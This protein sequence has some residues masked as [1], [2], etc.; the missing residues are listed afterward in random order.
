MSKTLEI[1]LI[2]FLALLGVGLVLYAGHREKISS[3][4]LPYDFSIRFGMFEGQ[5]RALNYFLL[6]Y[7]FQKQHGSLQ[8]KVNNNQNIEVIYIDLFSFLDNKSTKVKVFSGGNKPEKELGEIILEKIHQNN[9][10]NEPKYTTL[11]IQNEKKHNLSDKF[12]VIEFSSEIQPNGVFTIFHQYFPVYSDQYSFNFILGNNQCPTSCFNK[13]FN[14][15]VNEHRL[16]SKKSVKLSLVE[17]DKNNQHRFKLE[18]EN[19]SWINFL[20]GLGISLIAASIVWLMQF[21]KDIV[22]YH[23]KN[24]VCP[25]CLKKFKNAHGLGVH[26]GRIHKPKN[27]LKEKDKK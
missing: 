22:R 8:F 27:W 21:T 7:D 6:T 26:K 14:L 10:V 2:T 12:I 25:L 20:N 11:V 24:N 3:D 13:D 1:M 23:Q 9:P 18:T 4:S 5:P 15:N 17:G 16:S 19:K